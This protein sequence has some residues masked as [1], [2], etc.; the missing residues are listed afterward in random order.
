[1]SSSFDDCATDHLWQDLGTRHASLYCIVAPHGHFK[2]PLPVG[3][4]HA[5][6]EGHLVSTALAFTVWRHIQVPASWLAV[7]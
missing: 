5:P 3:G 2:S 6:F 4:T 7:K 1:M